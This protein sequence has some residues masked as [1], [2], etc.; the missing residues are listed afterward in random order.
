VH[1]NDDDGLHQRLSRERADQMRRDEVGGHFLASCHGRIESARSR[2][3]AR[4][5]G[6]AQAEQTGFAMTQTGLIYPS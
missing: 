4:W 6:G 3:P 1:S 2:A 5:A